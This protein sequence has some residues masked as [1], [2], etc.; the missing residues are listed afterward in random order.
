[1]T[2]MIDSTTVRCQLTIPR[3]AILLT[4]AAAGG[5]V[6]QVSEFSIVSAAF[7]A[8]MMRPASAPGKRSTK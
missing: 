6:V 5:I 4:T 8:V 1:M 7:A 2:A 3:T